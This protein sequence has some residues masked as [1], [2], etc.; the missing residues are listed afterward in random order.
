M[1]GCAGI[2][3]LWARDGVYGV[4]LNTSLI[5][6]CEEGLDHGV[7]ISLVDLPTE[8]LGASSAFRR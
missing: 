1:M 8:E 5:L 3:F 2:L 7:L 4:D 6:G